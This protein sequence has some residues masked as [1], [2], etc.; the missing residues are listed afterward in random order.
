MDPTTTDAVVPG[1]AE[2]H[3]LLSVT[4]TLYTPAPDAP[5]PG[6]VV[7]WMEALKAPG[8]FHENKTYVPLPPAGVAF[9]VSVLPWHIVPGMASAVIVGNGLTVTVVVV[10][11]TEVHP[12]VSVTVTLYTP[13]PVAVIPGLVVFWVE[14]AKPPGPFHANDANVPEP[15]D[16]VA[17][18]VTVAPAHN[19]AGVAEPIIAG[20]GLTVTEP[21]VP[22][23]ADVHP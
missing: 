2:T 16:G 4:V 6:R 15:P 23:A 13:L 5:I 14:A 9:K 17:F 20:V 12:L 8:P 10:P 18:K 11:A 22:G 21:V 7:F 1:D 19:N 3:P